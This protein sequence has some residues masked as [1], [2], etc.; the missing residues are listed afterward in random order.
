MEN[1]II[2]IGFVVVLIVSVGCEKKA[3]DDKNTPQQ[4]E[5]AT[6]SSPIP[7]SSEQKSSPE[8]VY[9]ELTPQ[10]EELYKAIEKG[11]LARVKFLINEKPA[12][13]FTES[14]IEGET[15]LHRAAWTGQK[16][17]AEFLI[18]KG[19]KVNKSDGM[20][21]ST[22]LIYA[23]CQG[24]KEV[25]ELLINKGAYVDNSDSEGWNPVLCAVWYGHKEV[26]ELLLRHG[27][28]MIMT[29]YMAFEDV[30]WESS[31][32]DGTPLQIAVIRGHK[33]MAQYL[34]DQKANVNEANDYG[35]TP[36]H[37]AAYWGRKDFVELLLSRGAKVNVRDKTGITPLQLA[38]QRGHGD[39]ADLLRQHGGVE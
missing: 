11:E 29:V 37:L 4:I 15:P 9:I 13:V 16:K 24:H 7:G 26:L 12:L 6:P 21:F 10:E 31:W 34:L 23:A 27:A 32:M 22:P 20:F 35:R 19:A 39:I 30:P 2:L 36:L 14:R 38:R 33:D 3:T 28:T 25:A 17:I 8:N 5:A 18:A 1:R